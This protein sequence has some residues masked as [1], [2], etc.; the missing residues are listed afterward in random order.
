[1][2]AYPACV[3]CLVNQGLNAVRRL[4]LGPEKEKEIALRAVKFLSQ[5]DALDRSPAYYAYFIQRIVK[6]IAGTEDP[7][8]E[9]KEIANRK[10]LELLPKVEKMVSGDED[11]E[12]AVRISALGNYIDFA[13]RGEL[14]IEK[15]IMALAGESFVVW[16]YERLKEKLQ[17]AKSVFIIGDNAGEIVFDKPL[18][19]VLKEMGIEVVY[20]V[21]G[22]PI[23]NDATLEDAEKVSMTKLCKVIDNGSDKVGTWLEDCSK[24]FLDHFYRSDVVISKGQANFETLSSADRDIFFLLVAKCD[25]IAK[26]TGGEV[27]RFILRFKE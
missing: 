27:R 23:L 7:F 12:K 19:R 4:N 9:Q 2:R 6:D 1:M 17:K 25:P 11:L 21:K 26:E 24:E 8:R 20:G 3:P 13:I 5:F 15:D 18:V 10:A 14:E 16:D 22:K